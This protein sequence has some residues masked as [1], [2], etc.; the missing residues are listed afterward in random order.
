MKID[1]QGAEVDVLKGATEA[2]S[3]CKDIILEAQHVDYNEG[4]PKFEEVR[5]FLESMGFYLRAQIVK[6]DV[7]GDYHFTRK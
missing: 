1:V 7:D 4:A 6:H 2:F 3:E 5:N